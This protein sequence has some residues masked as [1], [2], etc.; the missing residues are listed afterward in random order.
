[1]YSPLKKRRIEGP[2]KS[3]I[4]VTLFF[5]KVSRIRVSKA[6]NLKDSKC[7]RLLILIFVIVFLLELFSGFAHPLDDIHIYYGKASG[8]SLSGALLLE[9]RR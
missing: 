6:R 4:T 8:Y 7:S 5:R 2:D 3:N 9:L 1:M